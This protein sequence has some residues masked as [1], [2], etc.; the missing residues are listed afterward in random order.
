MKTLTTLFLLLYLP[1]ASAQVIDDSAV[2]RINNGEVEF[3][4]GRFVAYLADTTTPGFA[5]QVFKQKGFDIALLNF[6][7][8]RI[9]LRSFPSEETLQKMRED[10]DIVRIQQ[11]QSQLDPREMMDS[12]EKEGLSQAEISRTLQKLQEQSRTGTYMI[13]FGYHLNRE[14]VDRKMSTYYTLA[15]E[16]IGE[17]ARMATLRTEPGKESES[18]QRAEMLPFVE[19][20]A[21][22]GMIK[23]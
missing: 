13:E 22:I 2:D 14:M 20:T 7:P 5:R 1:V 23:D 6:E 8:V 17:A 21:L 4:E 16:V 19:Y 9:T 3:A 10:P 11:M 12:L 15:Y 18:M